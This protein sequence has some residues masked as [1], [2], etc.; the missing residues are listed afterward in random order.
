MPLIN[1]ILLN[2]GMQEF[3]NL[4]DIILAS[5]PSLYI[6]ETWANLISNNVQCVEFI[7]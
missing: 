5:R 7:V 3:T 2:T 1:K 6:I 4:N